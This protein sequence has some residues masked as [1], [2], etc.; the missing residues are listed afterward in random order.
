MAQ[1]LVSGNMGTKTCG[2]PLLFR[3]ILIATAPSRGFRDV[4]TL[5]RDPRSLGH[6]AGDPGLTVAFVSTSFEWSPVEM[7]ELP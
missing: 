1:A 5:S 4:R 3:F 6:Q 7:K 2:L